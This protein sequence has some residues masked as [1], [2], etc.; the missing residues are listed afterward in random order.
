MATKKSTK[1]T[2]KVSKVVIEPLLPL[3]VFKPTT[4][5]PGVLRTDH[6]WGNHYEGKKGALIKSGVASESWFSALRR[7]K[8]FD[9]AGCHVETWNG[10]NTQ[11]STIRVRYSDY[12]LEHRKEDFK[13]CERENHRQDEI[14]RFPDYTERSMRGMGLHVCLNMDMWIQSAAGFSEEKWRHKVS[15]RFTE[16]A[17]DK[18]RWLKAQWENVV[19]NAEVVHG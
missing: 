18:L 11:P 4:I 14:R 12:Q 17:V 8:E 6:D 13:E 2:R 5:A 16:E 15:V 3:E 10:G 9:L 7:S 1:Q 19:M